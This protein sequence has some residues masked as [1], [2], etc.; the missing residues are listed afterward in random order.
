MKICSVKQVHAELILTD[1]YHLNPTDIDHHKMTVFHMPNAT[2]TM[3]WGQSQAEIAQATADMSTNTTL[4]SI[5]DTVRLIIAL[6]IKY[7]VF[8]IDHQSY[9][10]LSYRT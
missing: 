5:H 1:R 6:P 10:Y 7:Q 8:T 4:A 2:Y 3:K 9:V